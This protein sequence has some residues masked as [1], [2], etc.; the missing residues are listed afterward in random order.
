MITQLRDNHI[1]ENALQDC[2]P[3]QVRRLL[4]YRLVKENSFSGCLRVYKTKTS[5]NVIGTNA[6]GCTASDDVIVTVNPNPAKP[7]IA[8]FDNTLS[9]D[10]SDT[11]QW[12]LAG[13]V[14]A[15]ANGQF[16]TVT[17]SGLYTVTVTDINGCSTTSDPTPITFTTI[18]EVAS[19]ASIEVYPNPTTGEFVVKVNMIRELTNAQIQITNELGQVVYVEK[20]GQFSGTIQR[21]IDLTGYATGLYSLQLTSDGKTLLSKKI[22]LKK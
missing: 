6:N 13:V 7:T 18:S 22:V 12:Y 3:K 9:T 20:S 17:Q 2:Y 11:Y 1:R 8:Q 4:R 10:L 21:P 5:Y 14:I 19:G 16:Y 15:G